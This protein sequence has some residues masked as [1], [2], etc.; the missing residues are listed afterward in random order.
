MPLFQQLGWSNLPFSRSQ[1]VKPPP[2]LVQHLST[3][4]PL[5]PG[6]PWQTDGEIHEHADHRSV[7]SPLHSNTAAA[8]ASMSQRRITTKVTS[9]ELFDMTYDMGRLRKQ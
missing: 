6:I 7:E 9:S 8:Y 4:P 2:Q 1:N 3:A 5:R